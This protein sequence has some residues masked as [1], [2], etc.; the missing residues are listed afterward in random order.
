M[1]ETGAQLDQGIAAHAPTQL[2]G[3][4]LP[5]AA[6]AQHREDRESRRAGGRSPRAAACH[7][8][9]SCFPTHHCTAAEVRPKGL[10]WPAG[11]E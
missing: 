11:S 2:G 5:E 10:S 4:A 7:T 6:R 9:T 3:Q 8:A 1:Q